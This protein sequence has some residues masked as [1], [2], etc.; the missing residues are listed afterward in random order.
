[1]LFLK[2]FFFAAA[3]ICDEFE[4]KCAIDEQNN[5]KLYCIQCEEIDG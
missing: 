1:M 2:M 4:N 5:Q 3:E